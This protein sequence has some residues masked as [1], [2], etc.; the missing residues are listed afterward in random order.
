MIER[1]L[2]VLG[3]LAH[4]EWVSDA[5]TE[6]EVQRQLTSLGPDEVERRRKLGGAYQKMTFSCRFRPLY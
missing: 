4:P 6:R 3:A 2:L 5:S 1:R